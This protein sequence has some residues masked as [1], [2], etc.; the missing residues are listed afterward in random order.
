MWIGNCGSVGGMKIILE[1]KFHLK[2]YLYIILGGSQVEYQ[3][4]YFKFDLYWVSIY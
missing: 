3:K 4:R 1:D 2:P